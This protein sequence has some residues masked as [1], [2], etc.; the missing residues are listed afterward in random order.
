MMKKVL[1]LIIV[2]YLLLLAGVAYLYFGPG[3][4]ASYTALEWQGVR[5]EA[6]KGFELKTY[7]GKG[8]EVY[9]LKKMNAYIKIALK[10]AVDVSGLHKHSQKV[11]YHLAPDPGSIYFVANPRRTHEAV[12]ARRLDDV[13]VYFSAAAP[14]PYTVVYMLDKV[15]ANASYRGK[16]LAPPRPVLPLRVYLADLIFAGGMVLPLALIT[17][18]LPLSARKPSEKYFA[19]DPIRCRE[20][21]VYFTTARKYRRKSSFCYL[22]LT[23]SRLMA[24]TFGKPVLEVRLDQEKPLIQVKGKR[25]IIVGEREKTSL[26]PSEIE[27]WKDCLRPFIVNGE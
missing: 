13:T 3:L 11:I 16:P 20:S 4:F 2:P 15:I 14:S 26:R 18:I 12:F 9:F 27:K 21:F 22:A 7:Q 1:I 8:W 24:F 17:L 10:P 19:G 25:I 6:P 5:A 23:A